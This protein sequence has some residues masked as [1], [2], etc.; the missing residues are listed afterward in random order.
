LKKPPIIVFDEATSSLDSHSEPSILQAINEVAANHTSVV[1]A[2]RLSTVVD[3][4]TIVVLD[5]G[6]VVE[7]GN[8]Q[9]LLALGGH[10]A[11]LWSVQQSES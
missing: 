11:H 3:A 7:Q 4:N 5:R 10:Y 6:Q 2:H 1:I 9:Q 8:H